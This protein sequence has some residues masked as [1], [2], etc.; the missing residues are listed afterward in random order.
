MF[1]ILTKTNLYISRPCRAATVEWH[2]LDAIWSVIS[3]RVYF[4]TPRLHLRVAFLGLGIMGR[5]MAANLVKAGHEVSVWN[6]TAGKT[7]DGARIASTPADA[8]KGVEGVWMCAG[9][10]E[11]VAKVLI[12]G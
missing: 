5:S 1:Q 4:S 10:T 6:R 8:A 12:G 11:A 7:V 2:L 3:N 9:D